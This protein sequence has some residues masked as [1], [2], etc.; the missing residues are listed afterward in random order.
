M[1]L[2]AAIIAPQEKLCNGRSGGILYIETKNQ[3]AERMSRVC[4]ILADGFEEVEALTVVD[5]LRRA[6]IKIEMISIS[7]ALTVRGRSHIEVVADRM[8][9]DADI[10]SAD[11]IVLPGG[12]PG[13]T[14]LGEHEGLAKTLKKFASEGKR[15]AAI[16]A[17]PSVLGALH[18][19]EGKKA[20]CYPGM[21][22]RLLGA[23]IVQDKK[24]VTDGN[25]TTSR[26]VGTAI[27]FALHLISLLEGESAAEQ[28]RQGI[29]FAHNK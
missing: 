16:C 18:L 3:E 13:V 22:D 27:P 23:E 7:D 19:L 17:A 20:V 11:M 29:V 24:V 9:K 28:V 1:Y 8:W 26:G 2:H 12:M 4:I 14:Y 21:E 10:S 5:L 15:L 25:I 6:D